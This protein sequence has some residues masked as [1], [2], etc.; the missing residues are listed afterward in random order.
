MKKKIIE[1]RTNITLMMD[2]HS[3][4]N[5]IA[6][7]NPLLLITGPKFIT[8]PIQAKYCAQWVSVLSGKRN[9]EIAKGGPIDPILENIYTAANSPISNKDLMISMRANLN[10]FNFD[11]NDDECD[12]SSLMTYE[13]ENGIPICRAL[14]CELCQYCPLVGQLSDTVTPQYMS[15]LFCLG[16]V[17]SP[18]IESQLHRE[19]VSG[20]SYPVGFHTQVADPLLLEYK[21]DSAIDAILSCS[22]QHH[23]LTITK[24]GLVA[25]V[26][27]TGN[28]D[29]FVILSL[30]N[31]SSIVEV[32]L[33]IDKVL[34]KMISSKIV[35]R[36]VIDIGKVN[37]LNYD[38]SVKLLETIL[39][40]D[41]V[42]GNLM[43][44]MLDSGDDYFDD[45]DYQNLK[46]VTKTATVDKN[47]Y[48]TF[49]FNNLKSKLHKSNP[50]IERN[51]DTLESCNKLI[52]KL[53]ELA[54]YRK[55]LL[56]ER[57]RSV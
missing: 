40:N 20:V 57:E 9:F 53:V 56:R 24:L 8:N 7:E 21:I 55:G 35:P 42:C 45:D 49:E 30:S 48:V 12:N 3:P 14:L 34:T 17:E 13:I 54:K 26:G 22:N 33:L 44:F 1:Y 31:V 27:T 5:D 29:T 39:T 10:K 41:N 28:N 52:H 6:V 18:L 46:D 2:P 37:H 4:K 38:T 47:P 36:L 11:F 15:D 51:Y 16:I 25:I 50:P 19:L 43:G 23:F 32:D